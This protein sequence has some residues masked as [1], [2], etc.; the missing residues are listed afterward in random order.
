MKKKISLMLSLILM[1]SL[2][3]PTVYAA[4]NNK[5]NKVIKEVEKA[6]WMI[7]K[8]I[9]KSVEKAD[10]E[11]DKYDREI[12]KLENK[13]ANE[14]DQEELNKI[15]NKI[16]ELKDKRNS[17]INDIINELIIVTN[18][19]A[20]KT[21]EKGAKEGVTIQCELIE[22]EIGGTTVMIDPLIVLDFDYVE[23][24]EE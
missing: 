6:N 21:V 24:D 8:E 11:M 9:T 18:R 10:R 15:D 3:M 19:I 14:N 16:V 1:L 7:E 22:V 17:K 20:L 5:L 23:S 4:D 12:E 2:F 13:K